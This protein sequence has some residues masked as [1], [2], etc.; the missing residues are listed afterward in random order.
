MS[1]P[2]EYPYKLQAQGDGSRLSA[3]VCEFCDAPGAKGYFTLS[4]NCQTARGRPL[5]I[6]LFCSDVCANKWFWK[7]YCTHR[8]RGDLG[9]IGN[10]EFKK[11]WPPKKR[12][13]GNPN[14]SVSSTPLLPMPGLPG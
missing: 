2:E 14:V 1:F 13:P 11:L 4:K 6:G 10:T 5:F 3:G 7:P 8:L 9:S 12:T